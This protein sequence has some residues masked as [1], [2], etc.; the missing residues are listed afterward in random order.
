M[1]KKL[2]HVSYAV[3]YDLGFMYSDHFKE[4]RVRVGNVLKCAPVYVRVF[5][6]GLKQSSCGVLKL[7]EAGA[8]RRQVA[9]FPPCS[10][11]AVRY[12]G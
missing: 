12:P 8:V 1:I 10:P 7:A 5:T 11:L 9:A 6:L 2:D 4:M 3:S